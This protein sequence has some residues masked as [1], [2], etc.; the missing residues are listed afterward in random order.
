MDVL[1]LDPEPMFVSAAK[2]EVFDRDDKLLS[3]AYTNNTGRAEFSILFDDTNYKEKFTVKV[4]KGDGEIK[5]S[6]DFLT[7]TPIKLILK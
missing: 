1:G 5:Y 4:T 2:V 7:P 3:E 6:V